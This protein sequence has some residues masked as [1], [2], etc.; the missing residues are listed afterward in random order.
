MASQPSSAEAIHKSKWQRIR[1]E[2]TFLG[3]WLRSCTARARRF[4]ATFIFRVRI[5]IATQTRLRPRLYVE[6][7]VLFLAWSL[8]WWCY[9]PTPGKAVL[10]LAVVAAVVTVQ[11]QMTD[12][13]RL[14]WLM[15]V[16]ILF[17]VEFRAIDQDHYLH[18]KEQSEARAKETQNFQAIGDG[19]KQAIRE[20]QRQFDATMNSMKGL[21]SETTGGNS[22]IY[23]DVSFVGGPIEIEIPGAHKGE[24]VS[25]AFPKFVGTYPLHNVFVAAVGPRGWLP[26]IDYG[27]IFPNE[28]GRPREGLA[29][30][31]LP[32]R[33]KQRFNLFINT[34]NGSYSQDILFLKVRDKWLW[35]S[36]FFKYGIKKTLRVWAAP[37]F[38]KEQLNTESDR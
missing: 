8:A 24:M 36:H 20:S 10:L 35:A 25:S 3:E 13:H 4:V 37:G 12:N 32:D 19:I 23:F 28:M 29:L 17:F 7:Q 14:V 33:P 6:F 31:F 9:P 2:L 18:E 30:A 34:S 15:I 5:L 27:T 22:Y 38:P 16:F 21:W 26:S 1:E 11:P